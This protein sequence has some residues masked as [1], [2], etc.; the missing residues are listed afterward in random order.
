MV[1]EFDLFDKAAKLIEQSKKTMVLT[2][3]GISTESGIPDFR[4]PGAGLWE[5]VD[6]MEVLSTK[7]LYNDPE[8]FYESGFKILISMRDAKPNEAHYILSEMEKRG[9]ISGII[10]QNIDSLHYKAGSNNIFEVHGQIR[11]GSCINCGKKV[12]IGI[13]DAKVKKKQIPPRCDN[14]SGILRPDVIMFGD[15]MPHDFE[16]AWR[17]V[18]SSDLL[19]V[20]GSSLTVSPVNYLP[21]LAEHL[22]IINKSKTPLDGKAD[23][24]IKSN[25]SLA[26]RNIWDIVKFDKKFDNTYK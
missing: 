5:K 11:S 3:A 2:G 9:I 1:E 20:I 14:C 26:L 4:S 24:V 13:L 7:V 10:T 23:V 15:S 19:L 21:G 6:P 17:E 8:K 22:L 25:A 12:D 18:E 16:V